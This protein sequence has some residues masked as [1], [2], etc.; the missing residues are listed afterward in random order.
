M[1]QADLNVIL[2]EILLALFAMIALLG[3]V[4]TEKDKLAPMLVW[5]TSG[6]FIALAI[7]IG[8]SGHGGTRIAFN[9][10]FVDD[11]VLAVFQDHH[12][13]VG[14][15]VLLMSQ[16]YMLRRGLLRFEYPILATLSVIGMMMMVSSGRPHDALH[17]PRA[18]IAGDVRR[19]L[20][21]PRFDQV[22]RGGPQVL[23][24]RRAQFRSAA[25]RRV[26]DL[27]LCRH[28]A[29]LGDHPHRVDQ[30]TSRS[31]CCSGWSS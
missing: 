6:L 27:R 11:C 24:A 1:I 17:G 19:R 26:A 3:A 9:G 12:P 13:A 8:A 4:Y 14:G 29:V 16:D 23:R 20:A 10:L 5:A 30:A 21:A 15:A 22:D 31:D 25:L 7:W 28:D 2:P 18:A